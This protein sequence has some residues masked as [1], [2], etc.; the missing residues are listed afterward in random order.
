M[1]ASSKAEKF[2]MSLFG[3]ALFSTDVYQSSVIVVVII[4]KFPCSLP[5]SARTPAAAKCNS[6][7]MHIY[8]FCDIAGG[9]P[10]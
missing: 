7:K 6:I 8:Y 1:E 5:F 4:I 9:I 3:G 2:K 10:L